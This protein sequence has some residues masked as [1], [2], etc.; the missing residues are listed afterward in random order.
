MME[1]P[2]SQKYPTN[3]EPGWFIKGIRGVSVKLRCETGL[4]NESFK[5][6]YVSESWNLQPDLKQR[7]LSGMWPRGRRGRR[8]K[9]SGPWRS[10][11]SAELE[12]ESQTDVGGEKQRRPECAARPQRREILIIN[13]APLFLPV[14]WSEVVWR[15]VVDQ[16]GK[17]S[18]CFY[19]ARR[20]NST[21]TQ[22][23]TRGG[24]WVD[25]A[26]VFTR[27]YDPDFSVSTCI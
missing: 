5:G 13:G 3:S 1:C 21:A 11:F 4:I 25:E 23:K 19:N 6:K 16:T 12:A 24:V 14:L 18:C 26:W 17:H 15:F 2:Q 10:G 27:F 20:C 8:R 9:S 22:R 7:F